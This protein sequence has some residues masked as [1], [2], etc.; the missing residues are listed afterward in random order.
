MGRDRHERSRLA[1]ASSVSFP[2]PPTLR[3]TNKGLFPTPPS[4]QALPIASRRAQ[5]W[6]VTARDRGGRA[7]RLARG[8]DRDGDHGREEVTGGTGVCEGVTGSVTSVSRGENSP[9]T[10]DTVDLVWP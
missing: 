5:Q 2:L 10:D 9:Y 6:R 1:A 8:V 4:E 7:R 3:W